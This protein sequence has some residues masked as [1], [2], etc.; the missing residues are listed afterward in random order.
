MTSDTTDQP[1]VRIER[2]F[3]APVERVWRMWT[4]PEQFAT[5]YGPAGAR[6]PSAEMDVTVGGRRLVRMEMDTPNGAMTMWF[7]GEYREVDEPHRLVY[8]DAMSD[9]NGR[10]LSAAEAGVPD[11]HPTVTEVIVELSPTDSGTRL[12]LTHVGVPEDSPGAL[13]WTMALDSLAE[14]LRAA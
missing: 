13:G 7:T 9:S 14:R 8:T 5:W 3:D 10:V 4:D 1:A 11:G 6:I 12:V 2:A